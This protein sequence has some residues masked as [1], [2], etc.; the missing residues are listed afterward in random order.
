MKLV[1]RQLFKKSMVFSAAVAG[2]YASLGLAVT[3][4]AGELPVDPVA[5]I[6]ALN[7]T[8]AKL[9]ELVCGGGLPL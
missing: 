4:Q 5:L 6:C 8:L 2:L 1:H 3:S 9:L 7:P